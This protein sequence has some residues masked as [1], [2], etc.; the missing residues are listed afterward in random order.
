MF[1]L[2]IILKVQELYNATCKICDK[3]DP[4]KKQTIGRHTETS[5]LDLLELLIMAKH[6]PKAHKAVYLIKAS[7]KLEIAQFLLRSLLE[8]KLANE[9]T[10]H[11]I[12]AK[13]LEIGRMLGGW[14]KSEK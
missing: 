10:L 11:Q 5:L 1:E 8:Q 7:A 4:S 13:T 14:L 2:G 9:T 3:L 12:N 6:A